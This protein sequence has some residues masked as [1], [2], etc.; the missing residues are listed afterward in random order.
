MEQPNYYAIIPA[1]VRYSD[2][3]PNAKLLYGEI[4]CL[5]NT[6]GYCFA[7]NNYF[8]KL[9]G[10]SKNTVSTWVSQL[11]EAG[12]ITIEI[13]YKDKQVIERRIGITKNSDSPIIKKNDNNIT[14]PNNIN[15]INIEIRKMRFSEEVTSLSA[16]I[17]MS[18][19]SANQFLSY[20]TEP[21]KSNTK[22]KF[23]LQQTWDTKRRLQRW[24]NNNFG[25]PKKTKTS[26]VVGSL[27]THQKAKEMLRKMNNTTNT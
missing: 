12:F 22:M 27:S 20:W 8:A 2:L 6:R 3:K 25:A 26:R 10:V 13:I 15:S 19:E 1:E 11:R 7:S 4:T 18:I 24:M 14:R 16:E 17:Q 5:T 23:E 21:N 9:Y